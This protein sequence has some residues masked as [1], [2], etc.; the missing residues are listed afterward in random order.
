ML[1]IPLA[2]EVSTEIFQSVRRIANN[3]ISGSTQLALSAA[4]TIVAFQLIK[5]SYDV[6]SDE[7]QGGFGGI[8]LSQILRPILIILAINMSTTLFG[9]FDGAVNY[10]ASN[11]S[12]RYSAAAAAG[13]VEKIVAAQDAA[14]LKGHNEQVVEGY[15]QVQGA[16]AAGKKATDDA[17]EYSRKLNSG[18]AVLQSTEKR[19]VFG[20][21]IS[22]IGSFIT[23]GALAARS[24]ESLTATADVTNAVILGQSVKDAQTKM[25][26]E[27]MKEG[28]TTEQKQEIEQG[29][30]DQ[31]DDT[32]IANDTRALS[33]TAAATGV[34]KSKLEDFGENLV[35]A[36]KSGSL[37]ISLAYWLYDLAYFILNAMV[38]I[39][40]TILTI[41]FP[42]TLVFSLFSHFKDATWKY[43]ATYINVS[44]WKVTASIINWTVTTSVPAMYLYTTTKLMPNLSSS[45]YSTKL[46]ALIGLGSAVAMLYIAGF[47][48]LTKVSTLTN[49]Y[50]P[51]ASVDGSASDSA[52]GIAS[53]AARTTVNTITQAPG[54][55]ASVAAGAA[56][57]GVSKVASVAGKAG[58]AT[59]NALG[60]VAGGAT[61]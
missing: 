5:L 14:I 53:T 47:I 12:G 48:A 39:I 17:M 27:N 28:L 19:G 13:V 9:W 60:K 3:G 6:M 31:V 26:E 38:E 54:K 35:D 1:N 32:K 56:T 7:Q 40:L 37:F 23:Q 30:R 51:N 44:F 25:G 4:C 15:Q 34:I 50:I 20:R 36:I 29:V 57:G 22:K 16:E 2:F 59:G 42:W 18:E 11:I 8:R 46:G 58:K 52:M 10:F 43:I 55:V 24:A 41:M 21:A 45:G 33:A 61:P 49:M